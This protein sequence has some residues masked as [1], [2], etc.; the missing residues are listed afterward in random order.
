MIFIVQSVRYMPFHARHVGECPCQ[1]LSGAVLRLEITST[2]GA[3]AAAGASAPP[4]C[5]YAP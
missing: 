2:P 5:T 1:A 3:G 4:S